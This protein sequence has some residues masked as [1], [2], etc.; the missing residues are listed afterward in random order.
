[1]GEMS[2]H[3]DADRTEN[4]QTEWFFRAP[5]VSDALRKGT[6][7]WVATWGG[8]D[9]SGLVC[10]W[11]Q[12]GILLETKEPEPPGYMFLPW[13]SVLYVRVEEVARRRVK[14]LSS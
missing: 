14:V 7:V 4:E 8:R 5:K 11:E 9:V 12:T 10:D 3:N 1:M 13:S 6:R 2:D